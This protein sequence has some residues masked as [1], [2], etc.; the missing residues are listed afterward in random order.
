MKII[1]LGTA[2][3]YRGGG[4]ATFNES[5]AVA[6]KN[7]D[8]E[9]IIYNFILQYPSF[10][11]P[12]KSQYS[13]EPNALPP[14]IEN[15]RKVNS[16]HPFNWI[17]IGLEL[18]SMAPELIIF[19]YWLPF[20]APCYSVIAWIAKLN[21]K[22]KIATVIDNAIPHEPKFYDI[23]VTKLF[24]KISDYFICMAQKVKED[25]QKLSSKECALHHHP[26]YENY[27]P[28]IEKKEAQKKLNL[29]DDQ[30]IILF[31]GF[32]RDYKGLDWLIE[33]MSNA[34]VNSLNIKLIIAGEFYVDAK[35][36][37]DLVEK[38]ELNDSIIWKND[39]IPDR[40]VSTY[41]CAADVVVLPYKSATQSGITQIAYYYELPV[42]ATDV[43]G[44][45][46]LIPH[47][48]T[49]LI[50]EPNS[51]SISSAIVRYYT[52]YL[53]PIYTAN[54]KID[55]VKFSWDSFVKTMLNQVHK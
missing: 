43:G 4:I 49:G 7:Q 27:G 41:F 11:F 33:A 46:E 5:L 31:F 20:M 30:K 55:K 9:V 3:P 12:G 19:R 18:K 14:D 15:L 17:K 51:G 48:R 53:E 54:M 2:Y 22:T 50:C 21:G 38:Y 36:Y 35:P 32:I 37:F 1:L 6:L 24:F 26:M 16:I 39:F 13:D 52:E 45:S 28:K 42:I 23:P 40:E 34:E 29:S 25:F 44:L 10:L 47:E 8:H